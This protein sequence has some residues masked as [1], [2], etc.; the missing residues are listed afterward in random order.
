MI[1]IFRTIR[2]LVM[3][4]RRAAV[5]PLEETSI[6]FTVW[7]TD[8]DVLLH[9]NNG[10]YLTLMDLGRADAAF[11]NGIRDGMKRHQWHAVVASEG[12]RFKESLP[13][14]E[15]FEL[16]TRLLGWDDKSFYVR[17]QFLVRGRVVAVGLVRVRFLKRTGGTVPASDV[18][19]AIMPEVTSPPLPDYIATWRSAESAYSHAT[20]IESSQNRRTTLGV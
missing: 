6:T 20:S 12:I 18:A 5:A 8:L 4:Q 14:F 7:P 10:R 15:R 17:Q 3:L 2:L 13:L 11:R 9:M 16:R 19:R 1:L